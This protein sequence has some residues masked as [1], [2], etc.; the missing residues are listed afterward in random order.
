LPSTASRGLTLLKLTAGAAAKVNSINPQSIVVGAA[1]VEVEM[2][3]RD[4]NVENLS[5]LP[6][7]RKTLDPQAY[8]FS[9]ERFN[10]L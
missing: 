10:K 9:E 8:T 5:S 7:T 2:N 4:G 3:L 1:V 6:G